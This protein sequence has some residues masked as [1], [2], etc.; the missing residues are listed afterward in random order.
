MK[1]G[2]AALAL[3]AVLA[4]FLILN[5]GAY[6]GYFDTL[7]LMRL[8]SP[9]RVPDKFLVLAL[10]RSLV[11][12]RHVAGLQ[13][14]HL[15]AS[16]GIFILLRRLGFEMVAACSGTAF[17]ALD[18]AAFE[19]YWQPSRAPEAAAALLCIAA[20]LA[21][22]ADRW[23]VCLLLML[24]AWKLSGAALLLPLAL[25][26]YEV[27]LGQRRLRLLIPFFAATLILGAPMLQRYEDSIRITPTAF[28][29][30]M[31]FYGMRVIWIP[32]LAAA[33]IYFQ[34]ARVRFGLAAAGALLLPALTL[35]FDLSGAHLYLPSIGLAI[36]AA[37]MLNR[38]AVAAAF[39]AIWIPAG[40]YA[41]RSMRVPLIETQNTIRAYR[42]QATAALSRDGV[43]RFWVYDGA[44]GELKDSGA[45]AMLKILA[46]GS[47]VCSIAAPQAAR[48]LHESS[49]SIARWHP[50]WGQLRV[51]S[52]RPE[53]GDVAY[54]LMDTHTPVWQL[55]PGWYSYEGFRRWMAPYSE[56]RLARPAHA[57]QFEILALVP[58]TLIAAHAIRVEV[59][60]DGASIG[61]RSV[62]HEGEQTLSWPVADGAAETAR[63]AIRVDP[64]YYP[65]PDGSHPLGL[66]VKGF[67]FK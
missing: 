63:I 2:I 53:T 43:P 31:R 27:F 54:I 18:T 45:E 39:F 14:I 48:A 41:A 9:Q 13:F 5:R 34:D 3:A 7:D 12:S 56:A 52:R 1:R 64:V 40:V 33:L 10:G 29:A 35:P 26:G 15:L 19:I 65:N 46:P 4:L 32:P 58:R 24:M 6:R 38:P 47:S 42:D 51:T 55:G 62:E 21:W 37:A 11:F 25:Y 67:G 61:M 57:R 49:V 50:E 16:A 36:L 17:F 59:R 60:I 66:L 20:L 44:P 22:V 8:A 23:L 30:A 28:L